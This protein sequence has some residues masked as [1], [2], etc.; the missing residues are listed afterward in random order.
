[1]CEGLSLAKY[2]E[3]DVRESYSQNLLLFLTSWNV[4]S[5]KKTTS[6]SIKD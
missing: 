3:K 6:L 1:M 4:L 2:E 5:V